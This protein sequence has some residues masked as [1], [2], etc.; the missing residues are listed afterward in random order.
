MAAE[1]TR[2]AILT[3]RLTSQLCVAP[4]LNNSPGSLAPF[5]VWVLSV[6]VCVCVSKVFGLECYANSCIICLGLSLNKLQLQN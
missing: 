4:N 5:C 2:L 6:C 3:A 1:Q